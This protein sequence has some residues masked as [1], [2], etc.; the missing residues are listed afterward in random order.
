MTKFTTHMG[1]PHGDPQTSPQHADP[2]EF[3]VGFSLKR[4]HVHEDRRVVGWSAGRHVDHPCGQQI[5]PCL[6]GKIIY[7]CNYTYI[8]ESQAD[9]ILQTDLILQSSK[10]SR[11]SPLDYNYISTFQKGSLLQN[12]YRRVQESVNRGFQTVVRDS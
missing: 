11:G 9:L 1:D 6:A 4:P 12:N 8:F 10:S 5:S 7:N 3:L 2:H